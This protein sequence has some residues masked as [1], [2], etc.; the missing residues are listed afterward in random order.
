MMRAF[1]ELAKGQFSTGLDLL[2]ADKDWHDNCDS[3]DGPFFLGF[4][5]TAGWGEGLLIASLLKR[6]AVAHEQKVKVFAPRQVIS[7]IEDDPAFDIQIVQDTPV[8]HDDQESD[9]QC[10]VK[11]FKKG[12]FPEARSPLAILRRAL[13]GDLLNYPFVKIAFGASCL[14]KVSPGA[15]IGIAWASM[16]KCGT[17]PIP[18]KS[19]PL[20]NLLSILGDVDA[21]VISFQRCMNDSDRDIL[22]QRLAKPCCI[23]EDKALDAEDQ[24]EIAAKVQMLDCMVTISTTTAHISACLGVPTVLLAAQ[25]KGHQWFWRAQCQHGKCLL[26]NVEV[27]LGG[28]ESPNWWQNCLSSAREALLRRLQ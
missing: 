1:K 9:V 25:R 6:H 10:A 4:P 26:P 12:N 19:M 3:L 21:Q 11:T 24:K 22:D 13:I 17:A 7:I 18:E 15:R 16:N 5:G 2:N 27:V 28:V 8:I 14:K 23:L 20:T